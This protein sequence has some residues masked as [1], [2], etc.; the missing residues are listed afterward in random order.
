MASN[1]KWRSYGGLGHFENN[2]NASFNNLTVDNLSIKNDYIGY[3]GIEG[4]LSISDYANIQGNIIIGGEA[5]IYGGTNIR[6][7]STFSNDVTVGGNLVINKSVTINGQINIGYGFIFDNDI[8]VNGNIGMAGSYI[9]MGPKNI[10]SN[11][12]KLVCN[13]ITNE[14]F[15]GINQPIET[16]KILPGSMFEIFCDVSS[17]V[18][19]N[20][21]HAHSNN[22][23]PA[24]SVI[25]SNSNYQG[26]MFYTDTSRC[27][28]YMYNDNT[29]PTTTTVDSTGFKYTQPKIFNSNSNP[30]SEISY[31]TGGNM[32]LRVKKRTF[33]SS[34][35][36]IGKT[37]VLDV[38]FVDSSLNEKTTIYTDPSNAHDF[39][40]SYYEKNST[41]M[42]NN[43]LTL[44]HD[45]DLSGSNV[46]LN[47]VTKDTMIGM[48]I[49]GGSYILDTNKSMGSIGLND[50]GSGNFIPIQTMI[51]SDNPAYQRTTMGINT[52]AP[53]TNNY[54]LNVNGKTSI[55]EGEIVK[56]QDVSFQLNGLTSCSRD[57]SYIIGYGS[58][59]V[60]VIDPSNIKHIHPFIY[61]HDG[62]STWSIGDISGSKSS[63]IHKNLV[64]ANY[65]YSYNSNYS[66]A[67]FNGANNY[68]YT[69]NGGQNWNLISINCPTSTST[70]TIRVFDMSSSILLAFTYIDNNNNYLAYGNASSVYQIDASYSADLIS[71]YVLNTSNFILPSGTVTGI[72]GYDSS[73]IFITGSF[74]IYKYKINNI[75]GV[76]QS[77]A[78]PCNTTNNYNSLYTYKTYTVDVLNSDSLYSI[79]VGD[80][81]IS[82]TN[83][84]GST[85]TTQ[86]VNGNLKDV[87]IYDL[88]H[89]I[90]VGT[91]NNEGVIY[92]TWDGGNTWTNMSSNNM[93]ATSG[94]SDLLFGNEKNLESICIPS[95]ENF[96]IN[97]VD[98]SYNS[99]SNGNLGYSKVFY[100]HF[101]NLFNIKNHTVLDICGSVLLD[102][103]LNV[104]KDIKLYGGLSTSGNIS[105]YLG[106]L[107]IGSSSQIDPLLT[108]T[109]TIGNKKNT[110]KTDLI[111]INGY[112]LNF[113]VSNVTGNFDLVNFLASNATNINLKYTPGV[114][115]SGVNFYDSCYNLTIGGMNVTSDGSGF[116]FQPPYLNNIRL[117]S[118]K[119]KLGTGIKNAIVTLSESP[120]TDSSY[121]I[122]DQP[123]IDISN[124][125][126]TTPINAINNT[127]TIATDISINGNLFVSNGF[128]VSGNGGIIKIAN[129]YVDSYSTNTG[130]LQLNGG[131]GINGNIFTSG[132]VNI[133]STVNSTSTGSGAFVVSGGVGIGGN[134]YTGKDS[135]IHGN[136]TVDGSYSYFNKV[137]INNTNGLGPTALSMTDFSSNVVFH[138]TSNSSG[139]GSG[140]VIVSGGLGVAGN[141]YLGNSIYFGTGS[142]H[143]SM[144]D[145]SSN[146]VFHST[147][148][149]FGTNS[150]SVVVSGGLGVA[151]N[152]YVGNNEYINGGIFVGNDSSFNGNVYI[153]KGNIYL[154]NVFFGQDQTQ[155]SLTD[156]MSDA[157]FHSTTESTGTDNGSIVI[158]GGIGVAGNIFVGKSIYFGTSSTHLSM[159]DFSNNVVFHS[160]T[161]SF[162]TGTGSVIVSGGVGIGGNVYLGK[163]LI[164]DGSYSYFNTIYFNNKNGLGPTT[165]SMTDFSSNVT[166]H[167]TSDSTGTGNG[168]I[169]ASG[170][171]GIAGNLFVGNS[172]YFGPYNTH[173]SMSDFSYNAVFYSTTN[174]IG[175]GSG[176]VVVNGGVGIGGNLY[177]GN[178][179]TVDG[180]YSYFNGVYI[181]SKNGLGVTRLSMTDFS[182]NVTMYSTTNSVGT[183]SG[184]LTVRGG[185]GISGNLYLGGNLTVDGTNTLFNT[186][187]I[188]RNG[189]SGPTILSMT[190]FSSNV[191]FHSTTDSLGTGSGSVITSGGIGIKGNVYIGKYAYVLGTTES[192]NTTT[193]SLIISGGVGIGGNVFANGFNGGTVSS[194]SIINLGRTL[195][196]SLRS[197]NNIDI[198]G[199]LNISSG[200][201]GTLTGGSL[202][203]NGNSGLYSGGSIYCADTTASTALNTGAFK[204]VGGASIGGNLFVG[205]TVTAPVI[206]QTSDYRI[207]DQI[208]Y[209]DDTDITVDD[210]LPVKYHNMLTHRDDIGFL[211]HEVQEIYPF[212]VNGEKDG[213]NY[214][215]L[216]YI[217]LIGI[218]VKE[219]KDLKSRIRCMETCFG[220]RRDDVASSAITGHIIE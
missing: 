62:G 93:L 54:S 111:N 37:G 205:G 63:G 71:P 21:L 215:N 94:V 180:S 119:F 107:N 15:M 169:V 72:D 16:Q 5:T 208:E 129:D 17:S 96:L 191:I 134:L 26:T 206:T 176:A 150:G 209:I 103:Y 141:L 220:V 44:I 31:E 30:D 170:G 133:S 121:V 213:E 87:Y 104:T 178:G 120:Y 184:A 172:I 70:T 22:T 127:Q 1:Q 69:P 45:A 200:I 123:Y 102:G 85:L 130:G 99:G 161:N 201:P 195:C 20:A 146:V 2:N 25:I 173:L 59:N 126:L 163:G 203:L 29:F 12:G 4:P 112:S 100:C 106:N 156:F 86:A 153:T 155:L 33:L 135:Y 40:Y 83:D 41:Y 91:L 160:T 151:G 167:S 79:F 49:C 182:S 77:T 138:S 58:P 47:L 174:S 158:S 117:N 32:L 159:T 43:A 185:V 125:V 177:L 115:K 187:Y 51:T 34:K 46:G 76:I 147:A 217:G 65:A 97:R 137:Y 118:Y 66:F 108:Q 113:D 140:S 57:P 68:F 95:I 27:S 114:G 9:F 142:T 109:I 92:V 152:L 192:I 7:T 128:S 60:T 74:G 67:V 193:G 82:V 50:D 162:G 105:S 19:T 218:L 42:T 11:Y 168:S 39:N 212:L 78:I 210:L 157:K 214:Q 6:G 139:T 181:N 23:E 131:I 175:T 3:F 144:T 35:V 75:S 84:G 101:P 148:D 122:S 38:S 149:S 196:Y 13:T 110:I 98:A 188:N 56:I 189:P 194:S 202:Y 136:L 53:N 28:M 116:L 183:A 216:N 80:N 132:N 198:S 190:D 73:Y 81:V 204:V 186:V 64:S 18:G 124:L 48:K 88:S 179:L 207:K 166:F 36:I 219:I 165:L 171:A 197:L 89:S 61:S 14:K 52:Y 143:L 55:T 211:A 10:L 199:V 90:V 8:N 24:Q 154:G 164:V 145:F